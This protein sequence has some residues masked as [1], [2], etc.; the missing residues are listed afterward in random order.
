M[1]EMEKQIKK[2]KAAE[3]EALM[4]REQSQNQSSRMAMKRGIIKR[5]QE[6]G[7]MSH[8][9]RSGSSQRRVNIREEESQGELVSEGDTGIQHIHEINDQR[10][11]SAAGT[12][13]SAS[14]QE[15]IQ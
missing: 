11:E 7:N 3:E 4:L 10:E 6:R 5:R 15:G 9:D 13:S 1:V 2:L 12:G 14:E 8:P